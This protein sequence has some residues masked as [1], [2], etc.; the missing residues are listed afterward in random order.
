MLDEAEK[1][2]IPECSPRPVLL[3]GLIL[4]NIDIYVS[5]F[6]VIEHGDG[7]QLMLAVCGV[8]EKIRG[9]LKNLVQFPSRCDERLI[10]IKPHRNREVEPASLKFAIPGKRTRREQPHTQRNQ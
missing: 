7:A 8:T 1:C 5:S 3:P 10:G 2:V 4:E 9:L 6:M